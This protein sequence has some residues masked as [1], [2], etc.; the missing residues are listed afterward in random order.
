[1]WEINWL[2]FPLQRLLRL[3]HYTKPL[4]KMKVGGVEAV[5][6]DDT[7]L[8][9]IKSFEGCVL[10]PYKDSVGYWTIGYGHLLSTEE[11]VKYKDGISEGL[12][13]AILVNDLK[14]KEEGIAK[15]LVGTNTPSQGEWNALVSFT[16]N[17]GLGTLAKS[18]L[19]KRYKAGDKKGAAE[20]FP[21]Y[22][23][24]G[25]KFSPG[26]YRRR[27]CEQAIF[28]GKMIADLNKVNWY[29]GSTKYLVAKIKVWAEKKFANAKDGE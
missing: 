10:H 29:R 20:V 27:L 11:H 6:I 8:T 21:W 18:T 22:N 16:F 9:L 24:A 7:G 2:E 15:L 14:S 19:L 25:N 4:E 28:N 1:M 5:H 12:A 23:R 26:I 17:L 3:R 13:E